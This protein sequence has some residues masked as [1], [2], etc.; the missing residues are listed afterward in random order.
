MTILKP[1]LMLASFAFVSGFA[2]Y[3]AVARVQELATP[4]AAGPAQILDSASMLSPQD[5]NQAR[6]V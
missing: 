5:W 4:V 1:I 3:L 6:R 2:G